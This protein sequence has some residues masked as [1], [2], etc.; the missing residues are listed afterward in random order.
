MRLIFVGGCERSGT[1]L[2]QKVLL[3]HSRVA[4]GPELVFTHRIAELH[5][6]MAAEYPASYTGRLSAFYDTEQLA[7]AFRGLFG[8]LFRR[9]GERKQGAHYF[10]EKTPS[11]IFAARELLRIFPDGLFVHV[12]RDGRDVL[13]SHRDVRLRYERAGSESYNRPSFRPWRVCARWN[14]A[15]DLHYELEAD[16]SFDGRYLA[17]RYEKLVRDP[18]AQVARLFEFLQLEMEPRTLEPE[19]VTSEEIGVP[20]DGIWTTQEM[21]GMGFDPGG[22][23]RWARDLPLPSRLLGRRLLARNLRRLGYP[24]RVSS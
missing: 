7:E 18:E 13:A 17:L 14:R 1:S 10:A 9:L 20:I 16:P 11:N 8:S 22:I 12:I 2:V 4:G 3:S 5:R 23:D 21:S 6:I 24:A 15:I 19:T